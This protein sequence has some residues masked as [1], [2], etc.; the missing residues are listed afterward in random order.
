MCS[1]GVL[2]RGGP[3]ESHHQQENVHHGMS[4]VGLGDDE[5]E[6]NVEPE[7]TREHA[8]PPLVRLSVYE[9]HVP[10]H[11]QNIPYLDN[12]PSMPDVDALTRDA[13]AFRSAIW[14][15]SRPTVLAK[16]MYFPAK[17]RLTRA[18]KMY[19]VREYREMMVWESTP[20]VYKVRCRR[21]FM[22]C[23]WMLRVIK[24]E[25][26]L[27]KVGKYIS[28]HRCEMDTF[29]ENRFNLDVDLISLVLILHLEVSIRYKIKEC[30]TCIHQEY[31]CTITKRKAYLGRKRAFEIIYGDWNKSF[32]SLTSDGTHVYKKYDINLLI[33]VAVDANG[34]IF[35]LA[36]AI[37]ANESEET[38]TL[39]LNHLKQHEP[40]AYHRYCVRHLKA[41]F[42]KKY[43]IKELHDLMWMAETEH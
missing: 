13:D 12:L 39:F 18:I 10:F 31:G 8:P 41:K 36:F 26:G 22:G 29:N 3:S 4:T 27:W 32:S 28:T 15:E 19:S 21:H 17:A 16:G 42:Q 25:R 24:K 37:C 7:L 5:E 14:D 9:S 2:D 34:Q 40:Y 23:N 20:E 38:W 35:P 11:E 43:P 6:V 30:I 1:S 33:V